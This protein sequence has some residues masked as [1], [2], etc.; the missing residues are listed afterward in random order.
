MLYLAIKVPLLAEVSSPPWS[1]HKFKRMT[2]VTQMPDI[3]ALSV[4]TT[5]VV[6]LAAALLPSL[7]RYADRRHERMSTTE[8]REYTRRTHYWELRETLYL[9]IIATSVVALNIMDAM[10]RKEDPKSVMTWSM[11]NARARITAYASD[12]VRDLDGWFY[13]AW[14]IASGLTEPHESDQRE[15]EGRWVDYA[16]WVQGKLVEQIRAALIAGQISLRGIGEPV[17]YDALRANY[18]SEGS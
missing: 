18:L 14:S 13:Q 15:M 7:T 4:V 8:E 11:D 2:G 17:E 16:R 10:E 5:G 1:P 12:R 9:D 3:A 6:G